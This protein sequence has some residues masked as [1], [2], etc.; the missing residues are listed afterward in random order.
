MFFKV[1]IL[2]V[3]L[4]ILTLVLFFANPETHKIVK[5]AIDIAKRWQYWKPKRS[6]LLQLQ[7]SAK[8]STFKT[9]KI[10]ALTLSCSNHGRLNTSLTSVLMIKNWTL[11]ISNIDADNLDFGQFE[12]RIQSFERYICLYTSQF[13]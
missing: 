12:N 10:A 2:S 6:H 11:L 13:I 8:F 7:K 9:T 1:S 3:H 4:I 5:F